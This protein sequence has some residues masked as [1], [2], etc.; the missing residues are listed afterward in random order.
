MRNTFCGFY[1][2]F[3]NLSELQNHL[4]HFNKLNLM[5]GF[6][7]FKW[8]F[9]SC[10]HSVVWLLDRKC[11]KWPLETNLQNIMDFFCHLCYFKYFEVIH[12]LLIQYQ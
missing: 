9:A 1:R 5:L 8:C 11:F 4:T 2:F 12:S 6:E 3:S 10:V 7:L